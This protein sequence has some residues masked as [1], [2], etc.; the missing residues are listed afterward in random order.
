[1]SDSDALLTVDRLSVGF[2]TEAGTIT[3]VDGVDFSIRRGETLGLV[4]ESG[5]GKSVT[6]MSIMR[7]LPSPPSRLL[8]GRLLFD[9]KDLAALGERS[10]QAIRGERIG[11]IFQEPMTSLNPV[12]TVGFQLAE[13]VRLHRPVGK[14]AARQRA[15]E[16]LGQ[17]GVSAPERRLDQYPHELSGGLRQRVMIA[18]AIACSPDLV[19]ADEPTTALDV[20]IQAQILDLLKRLRAEL[21][22]AVLMITHDLGVV[23]EFCDR[24]VVMYA[25]RVVESAPATDLFAAPRHPYTAGLLAS[26]PRLSRRR[27]RLPT[28]PGMVPA[29]ADRGDFCPFADRCARVLDRCRT[30]MPSLVSSGAGTVGSDRTVACWNPEP[31]ATPAKVAR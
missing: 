17:V 15:L 13:A 27:D 19:I 6:A 12:W 11:M 28:I 8:G 31:A 30:A 18:M 16:L 2:N 25:G 10:M 26:M 24:V 7:L 14:Q 5:C 29:P 20:T 22:M 9:G 21:G 4:G 3:V 23:A 1:M